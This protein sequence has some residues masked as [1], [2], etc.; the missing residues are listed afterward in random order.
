[1]RTLYDSVTPGNIPGDAE[2]VGGYI[3]GWYAWGDAGWAMFPAAVPVRIAVH[4]WTDAGQ[5]LDVEPGD[6]APSDAPLWVLMRQ[7]AGQI[8]SVYCSLSQWPAVQAAFAAQ[9]MDQPPTWVA[10]YPGNGAQLYDGSVAH[11]YEGD[12]DQGWDRSVV[13]DFPGWPGV[14][15]FAPIPPP[16]PKEPIDMDHYPK[17]SVKGHTIWVGRAEDNGVIARL[18]WAHRFPGGE[19]ENPVAPDGTVQWMPFPGGGWASS[20]PPEISPVE[21]TG[22]AR[23][24]SIILNGTDTGNGLPYTAIWHPTLGWEASSP[25]FN[26]GL[27]APTG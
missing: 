16:S 2:M 12:S 3:D 13:I 1:M 10:A 8:G 23:R 26:A 27:P 21:R 20:T 19:W 7:Q 17:A 6:A 18:V 15:S 4:Q 14:D 25:R 5:V 9:G 22:M 11:Q 24:S